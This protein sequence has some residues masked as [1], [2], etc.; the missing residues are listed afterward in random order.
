MHLVV[1]LSPQCA[2]ILYAPRYCTSSFILQKCKK[3]CW[4]SDNLF[5]AK[6]LLLRGYN[7]ATESKIDDIKLS[8][9]LGAIS[10]LTYNVSPDLIFPSCNRRLTHFFRPDSRD[11]WTPSLPGQ[12]L[13]S[14]LK[15]SFWW[16]PSAS[17]TVANLGKSWSICGTQSWKDETILLHARI[18]NIH[19]VINFT[20]NL[21]IHLVVD[22]SPQCALILYAPR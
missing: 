18:Y 11:C 12:G 10:S 2:L 13:I 7:C 8:T 14:Y 17:K 20:V 21:V 3:D 22:S 19:M 9:H 16:D 6:P 5:S 4:K 15:S 1:D